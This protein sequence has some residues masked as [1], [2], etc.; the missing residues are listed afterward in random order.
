MMIGFLRPYFSEMGPQ[1]S[2]EMLKPNKNKVIENFKLVFPEAC[3]G[4]L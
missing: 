1:K 3:L 4:S 2:C